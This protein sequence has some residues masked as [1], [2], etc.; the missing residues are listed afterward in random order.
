[1][2][3]LKHQLLFFFCTAL[4]FSACTSDG[5]QVKD[6]VIDES[7]SVTRIKR[8]GSQKVVH[9][10]FMADLNRII[11]NPSQHSWSDIDRYYRESLPDRKGSPHYEELKF[12]CIWH[13]FKQF[14]LSEEGGQPELEFY[15]REISRMDWYGD[16]RVTALCLE[17]L[18]PYW[19]EA[20]IKKAA[21]NE[22]N[23]WVKYN[24][25]HFSDY[26]MLPNH[27]EGLDH[28]LRLSGMAEHT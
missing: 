1:M 5:P 18:K 2:L 10:H 7:R 14:N 16:V 3:S 25:D 11:F 24:N 8:D 28:L 13:L 20:N 22:Y 23:K 15:Y 26:E 21:K 6:A 19:T 17:G 27:Q 12:N 4:M 9:D